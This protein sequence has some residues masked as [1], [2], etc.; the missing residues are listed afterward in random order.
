MSL[1]PSSDILKFYL[2]WS[3][4]QPLHSVSRLFKALN[5]QSR[6]EGLPNQLLNPQ[7]TLLVQMVAD[8]F[9]LNFIEYLFQEST[10]TVFVFTEEN[11]GDKST[12]DESFTGNFARREEDL[13]GHRKS[14]AV[15]ER[16]T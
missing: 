15:Y 13:G 4:N 1:W 3:F 12:L 10:R 14:K 16:E 7:Q 8:K 2:R 6:N 9:M 5:L 11:F